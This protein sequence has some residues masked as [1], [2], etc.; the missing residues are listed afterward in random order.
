MKM[1]RLKQKKYFY[2]IGKYN[3]PTLTV[4]PGE[5][6]VVETADNTGNRVKTER[7]REI[8]PTLE[9]WNPLSGPI[10]VE[11]TK[12]GDTLIVNINDIKPLF[13]QGWGGQMPGGISTAG[14]EACGLHLINEPVPYTVKICPIENGIIRIPLKN[15]KT[16][17]VQSKPFI[18]T[19]GVAPEID[20][21]S[22]LIC[23]RF[24]GNMDSPD[25]CKGN[26]VFL[27]VSVEGAFLYL[28][29]VH[30]L[31]GD[32]ELGGAPVEIASE[33]TLTIDVIKDKT[34]N[35]PRIESP[36][37]I[38]TVGNSCPLDNSLRIAS[39]EMLY[40]LRDEYGFD[41]EDAVYLSST[42]FRIRVNEV[43]NPINSS[44]SVMF[45]KKYLPKS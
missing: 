28:G 3:E 4:K 12:P 38:M 9:K 33:C 25:T 1:K 26:K 23:G 19:I 15:G 29:D 11:G 5:T 34:I 39:T 13:N 8:L 32:G 6:I 40:W 44:V 27:P 31:Q 10:F 35:W 17:N 36:E 20:S 14:D 24:G 16:I 7:D 22:C 45:P 18:G 42:V 21:A 2:T 30:A 41:L 43:I 37:Y